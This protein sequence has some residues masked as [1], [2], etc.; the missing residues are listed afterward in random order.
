MRAMA[1]PALEKMVGQCG[2]GQVRREDETV[3]FEAAPDDLE[4]QVGGARVVGQIPQLVQDEE[5]T[6]EDGGRRRRLG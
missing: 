1:L 5:P 4:E 2:K 6:S 3:P